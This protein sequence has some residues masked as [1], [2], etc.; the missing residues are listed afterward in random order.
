M[1]GY[2]FEK[3]C[4]KREPYF[5]LGSLFLVTPVALT[6]IA[7]GILRLASKS[8]PVTF[9]NRKWAVG[10]IISG[11]SIA[12][13]IS[14]LLLCKNEASKKRRKELSPPPNPP[15]EAKI[16]NSEPSWDEGF[17][18]FGTH[19]N[20]PSHLVAVSPDASMPLNSYCRAGK[21]TIVYAAIQV[22]GGSSEHQFCFQNSTTDPLTLFKSR[23]GIKW[24]WNHF[25]PADFVL[26]C[27]WIGLPFGPLHILH[28][29]HLEKVNSQ[30]TLKQNSY[31]LS[32]NGSTLQCS[33]TINGDQK[34]EVTLYEPKL[35]RDP[36][37]WLHN[38]LKQRFFYHRGSN[39]ISNSIHT[40]RVKERSFSKKEEP[41]PLDPGEYRIVNEHAILRLTLQENDAP[42]E[43]EI[44]LSSKEVNQDTVLSTLATWLMEPHIRF[45]LTKSM[46]F[47]NVPLVYPTSLRRHSQQSDSFEY[48]NQQ[49]TLRPEI[50]IGKE[51][52][53]PTFSI[54]Q[55]A[56]PDPLLPVLEKE[57]RDLKFF[58][59][60][61]AQILTY[62]GS[63]S[64]RPREFK[65]ANHE[66]RL[67][68]GE[69]RNQTVCYQIKHFN[70]G[71]F[72]PRFITLDQTDS[73]DFET[74]GN[75][76]I[77]AISKKEFRFPP[78][79]KK[80]KSFF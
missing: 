38:S 54:Y 51:Q 12:L 64:I 39:L 69:Y 49:L 9:F 20:F 30:E 80:I 17:F 68:P 7:I 4:R 43:K 60:K 76:L 71:R 44:T 73:V 25:P 29:S 1:L 32:P 78:D 18:F 74:I 6:L 37:D 14:T 45:P 35:M 22:N 11:S 34:E 65:E 41:G 42:W 15:P 3:G 23:F 66:G 70:G 58:D 63:F 36:I 33:I 53:L 27:G 75:R 77:E 61:S 40:L 8:S 57:L 5:E 13:L 28:P 47:G 55:D 19:I 24:L 50:Y 48:A 67:Q 79:P 62:A 21:R 52:Q 31:V 46:R 2:S 26:K 72:W 56:M 16:V 59:R 10:T